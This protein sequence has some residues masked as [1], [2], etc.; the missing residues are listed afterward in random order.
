MKKRDLN[1][2]TLFMVM[3]FFIS[4]SHSVFA[5]KIIYLTSMH[6]AL[7][8][9][10]AE[11]IIVQ[12]G[13]FRSEENARR[14]KMQW[15][16]R[17]K[18]PIHIKR[19]GVYYR[20]TIGPVPPNQVIF[21]EHKPA[22]RV[23]VTQRIRPK[24]ITARHP[25]STTKNQ[26][27]PSFSPAFIAEG[28]WY[29]GVGAG[30]L[31]PNVG[32]T[33]RVNNGSDFDPPNNIDLYSTQSSNHPIIAIQG[34]K[35]W[36][37][38]DKLLPGYALG[39]RYQYL[40][41]RAISGRVTQY[42]TS[43][44]NN[45]AYNWDI[46]TSVVSAYTKLQLIKFGRVIPYLNGGIGAA[47]NQSGKYTEIG[48]PD[49]DARDTP[50]FRS[51]TQTHFAYDLGLGLDVAV[52]PQIVLSLGYDFQSLGEFSSGRGITTWNSQQ[53]KLD[54]VYANTALLSLTY[55]FD[56]PELVGHVDNMK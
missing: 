3:L 22:Q 19:K 1:A 17:V 41:P 7:N 32:S 5:Q 46:Q 24:M 12:I 44:F 47:F 37:R 20:V 48:N 49:I 34:G 21:L 35:F 10:C 30:V 28:S 39:L 50:D 38:Q 9:P 27:I 53:L 23:S 11:E 14:M 51:G 4:F 55:L 18:Y 54:N 25:L 36:K 16:N 52:N 13:S 29:I 15:E 2:P 33:M 43:Q 40:F 8:T 45:Y 31:K 6:E 56:H 26:K 42:S